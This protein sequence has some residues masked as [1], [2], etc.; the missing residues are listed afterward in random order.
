MLFLLA[1]AVTAFRVNSKHFEPAQKDDEST[2]WN[3]IPSNQALAS[4]KFRGAAT[5]KEGDIAGTDLRNASLG[6]K[7]KFN[8]NSMPLT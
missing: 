2:F 8:S 1:Y 3:T 5:L 4:N 7:S 6:A